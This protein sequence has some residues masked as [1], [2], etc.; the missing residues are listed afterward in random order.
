MREPVLRQYDEFADWAS[1]SPVHGVE[2]LPFEAYAEALE[3]AEEEFSKAEADGGWSEWVVHVQSPLPI[4]P[5]WHAASRYVFQVM[6]ARTE[7]ALRGHKA[8]IEVRYMCRVLTQAEVSYIYGRLSRYEQR[9]VKRSER[10]KRAASFA[11]YVNRSVGRRLAAIL[12][13]AF[14]EEMV[15]R[16][17]IPNGG[18]TR[19]DVP[20]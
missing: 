16:K 3:R 7:D 6:K 18:I 12:R 19:S 4:P 10:Q 17:T 11:H 9:I 15:E 8:M 13:G 1:Q 5:W 20:A 14:G 2:R